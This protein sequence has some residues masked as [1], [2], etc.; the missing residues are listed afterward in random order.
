MALAY[1]GNDVY[2]VVASWTDG[3]AH[4]SV[5]DVLPRLRCTTGTGTLTEPGRARWAQHV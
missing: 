3:H 2:R 1:F 4:R 5:R